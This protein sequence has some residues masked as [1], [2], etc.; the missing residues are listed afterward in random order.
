MSLSS[1]ALKDF[2]WIEKE[3]LSRTVNCGEMGLRT[4]DQF[5]VGGMGESTAGR[6]EVWRGRERKEG[7]RQNDKGKEKNRSPRRFSMSTVSRWLG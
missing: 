1:T 5:R 7:E 4:L 6:K 2:Q 3:E